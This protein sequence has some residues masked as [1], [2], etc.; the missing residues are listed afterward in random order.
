MNNNTHLCEPP[1]EEGR[2][3]RKV[4]N[5]TPPKATLQQEPQQKDTKAKKQQ[6]RTY[7]ESKYQT[8][9]QPCL[10]LPRHLHRRNGYRKLWAYIVLWH[11]DLV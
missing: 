1:Q 3:D 10:P 6:Q 5:S 4:S 8:N 7:P 11:W 2:D 9:K